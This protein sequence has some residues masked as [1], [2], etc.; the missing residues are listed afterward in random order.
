MEPGT[1]GPT[2][3]NEDLQTWVQQ[4]L[5]PNPEEQA[6]E[7]NLQNCPNIT[8]APILEPLV[9]SLKNL[10]LKGSGIREINPYSPL[11]MVLNSAIHPRE[12]CSNAA[13]TYEFLHEDDNCAC[14]YAVVFSSWLTALKILSLHT[15]ALPLPGRIDFV[16]SYQLPNGKRIGS[17][18]MLRRCFYP[19]SLRDRL[20]LLAK[21]KAEASACLPKPLIGSL[22]QDPF[23]FLN[24]PDGLTDNLNPMQLDPS[25]TNQELKLWVKRQQAL[26]IKERVHLLSLKNCKELTDPAILEPLV[27][28]LV[29]LEL[30]GSGI[31]TINPHSPLWWV[32]LDMERGTQK[33]GDFSEISSYND[34]NGD[35]SVFIK[36]KDSDTALQ[37]LSG[38][39]QGTVGKKTYV[40]GFT[41][42]GIREP[43]CPP[44]WVFAIGRFYNG[45]RGERIWILDEAKKALKDLQK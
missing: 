10:K 31:Q 27:T 39:V 18:M 21:A 5:A 2:S 29:Q 9:F 19:W 24:L 8:D 22:N 44:R 17:G 42:P 6:I 43:L 41:F 45:P 30:H 12:K 25:T 7:L 33:Q 4:Q 20:S 15:L 38:Y 13:Y 28:S 37:Y 3:T 1:F 36:F 35:P 14:H 11:W 32:D 16:F 34:A 23:A 26:P 40:T